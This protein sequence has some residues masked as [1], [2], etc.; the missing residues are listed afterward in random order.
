[1]TAIVVPFRGADGKRRLAPA[2]DEARVAVALAMLADVLAACSAV[3]RTIVVTHDDAAREVAVELGVAA[4]D[5]PGGGQGAA[6]GYALATLPVAPTLVVNADLP[7]LVPDDVRALADAIP[8][9]GIAL[10]PARDGTTNALGLAEPQL[11]RPLYGPR[12][13]ERFRALGPAATIEIP[14]LVDDV[15]TLDDLLRLDGRL[16][17]RTQM[18]VAMAGLVSVS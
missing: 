5:D 6:V 12:S 11:F 9:G 13:A 4:L 16:G 3:A 15:D 17:P 1:M 10:A 18:A 7:C 2:Q 14:S 8:T